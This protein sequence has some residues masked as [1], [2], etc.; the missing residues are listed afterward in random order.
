MLRENGGR[1]GFCGSIA[2]MLASF[3]SGELR[4]FKLPGGGRMGGAINLSP[5]PAE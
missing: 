3:S 4:V 1:H 5:M 2:R